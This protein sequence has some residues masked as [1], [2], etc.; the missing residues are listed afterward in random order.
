MHQYQKICVFLV[1]ISSSAFASHDF[2]LTTQYH[3]VRQVVESWLGHSGKPKSSAKNNSSSMHS[4]N[5][6]P[7][8]TA[9]SKKPLTL[10]LGMSKDDA[11]ALL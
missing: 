3:R 2:L 4:L 8:K 6:Y 11:R 7:A 5:T 10:K 9:L 1:L